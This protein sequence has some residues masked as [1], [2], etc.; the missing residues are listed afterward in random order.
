[1]TPGSLNLPTISRG[2]ACEPLVI[3]IKDKTLQTPIDFTGYRA[4]AYIKHAP[5]EDLI[6]DLAPNV[7]NAAGGEIT[8]PAI[9]P[10]VTSTIPAG[11]YKW[12]LVLESST[13]IA[14]GPWLAGT[15]VVQDIITH[16]ISHP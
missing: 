8:I 7:T 6:L 9:S 4:F 14:T 12:D 11:S 2:A 10:A 13:G 16:P 1:M 3:T 5:T 15:V